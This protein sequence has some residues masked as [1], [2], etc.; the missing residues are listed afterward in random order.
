MSTSE[1]PEP[2]FAYEGL[3]PLQVQ[4]L[5]DR[6]TARFTQHGLF[7]GV[8][9]DKPGEVSEPHAHAG[10]T[11]VTLNGSAS[12]RLDQGEWRKVVPGDVTVIEDD[13]LHA[14]IAGDRGWKYLFA[15]SQEEAQ[16]QG[17]I[18]A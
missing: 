14:V 16:R 7:T 15:C 8:Y 17:L 2:N 10:A 3:N 18:E 4:E 6:L 9:S 11:L 1:I 5:Q 12:I 13:Q